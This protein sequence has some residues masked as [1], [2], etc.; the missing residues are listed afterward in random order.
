MKPRLPAPIAVA[1]VALL[2]HLPALGAD[3]T[4]D[5]H[6]I[7]EQNPRL[8]VHGLHDVL[9]LAASNYWG[10][11]AER[12]GER[13]FRPLPLLTYALERAVAPGPALPHATNVLLHALAAVAAL[14]LFRQVVRHERGALVGAL[15][16]AAHPLHAEAV[17]GVVG[18]A[19]VLALLFSLVALE[20]TGRGS[21]LAGPAFF[22]A[23]ASKESA[24]AALAIALVRAFLERS[25]SWRGLA[26]MAVALVVY[27]G[28]RAWALGALLPGEAAHTLGDMPV[29][30]RAL[31]A[32]AVYRDAWRSVLLPFGG[33]V[34]HFPFPRTD[35]AALLAAVLVQIAC[36]FVLAAGAGS[37]RALALG[38]AGFELALLPVSN[39][40]PI[41]V[42]FAERLLYA[43]SA[44]AS[45][46]VG[47][48]LG[49]LVR[50][51]LARALTAIAIGLMA[52]G[53]ARNDT[54]WHDELTLW[55][56]T[57]ERF[58]EETLPKL[59]LA[60]VLLAENEREGAALYLEQVV[61]EFPDTQP[62]KA[63]AWGLLGLALAKKSRVRSDEALAEAVRLA[64]MDARVFVTLARVR[65]EENANKEALDAA[66]R[67]AAL[68]PDAY[69][70]WLF[71]GLAQLELR[72]YTGAR[73]SFT[74]AASVAAA[75]G[76]AILNRAVAR[77]KLG[78]KAG[79]LEDY[80]TADRLLRRP[81][82]RDLYRRKLAEL[83]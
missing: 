23:L 69:E 31:V 68:A 42:V 56:R 67:A 82:V 15:L 29:S 6:A 75:P 66:E 32:L 79:A 36:A 65:Y 48:A 7:V 49:P 14:A 55:H 38:V 80:A 44:W 74:H 46:A 54:T 34:A 22:L 41:G 12:S 3:F 59:H 62:L 25:A 70:A 77:E 17:A 50:T 43:P 24:V 76:E 81:E 5:D 20:R 10:P 51:D 60:E 30:G 9:E 27:V 57:Q 83:R 21:L 37:R 47:A 52:L 2:A 26:A 19:E 28:A 63:K 39:L 13:L 58:P 11:A 45:L 33:T 78:D 53:S 73:E 18:R 40:V 72:D 8:S 64:P 1:L 61:K 16:F 4:F 71:A 35:A